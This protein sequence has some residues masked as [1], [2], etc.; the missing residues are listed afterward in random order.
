MTRH[1]RRSFFYQSG[2]SILEVLI[3]IMVVGMVMV[4]IASVLTLSIKNTA[5]SRYRNVATT[6]AQQAIEVFRREKVRLGWN[7][8]KT[9]AIGGEYCWNSLPAG[10]D[11]LADFLGLNVGE[12]QEGYTVGGTEFTRNVEILQTAD[13]VVVIITVSWVDGDLDREV[14]QEQEFREYQ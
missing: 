1:P 13:E 6:E 7:A 9:A 11:E 14:V 2:Q 12:C 4:A 5:E 8:F 3:A 10:N